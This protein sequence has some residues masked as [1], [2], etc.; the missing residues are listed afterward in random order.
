MTIDSGTYQ[1]LTSDQ[2][3]F[4]VVNGGSLNITGAT[5]SKSGDASANSQ[6]NTGDVSDDYNFYGL[7]S[8]IVVLGDGSSGTV[9]DSTIDTTSGAHSAALPTDRGSGTVTVT[10]TN[11]FNTSSAVTVT[12]FGFE[13]STASALVNADE[14]RWGTSGSNGATVAITVAGSR[15]AGKVTA[16]DSSSITMKLTDS[17]TLKGATRG[18]VTV[19]ADSSST[20]TS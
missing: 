10:G 5:T 12:N 17:S 11:V 1:S 14:N 19:T 3:V 2:V 13:S 9:A 20:H 4:L 7:N 16:G 6:Q 15:L 8:A 18:S